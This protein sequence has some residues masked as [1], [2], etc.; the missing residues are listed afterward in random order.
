M[1]AR[2][3]REYHLRMSAVESDLAVPAM[4]AEHSN[5]FV[6]AYASNRWALDPSPN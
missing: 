2:M 4:T 1:V 3:C 6:I 5:R